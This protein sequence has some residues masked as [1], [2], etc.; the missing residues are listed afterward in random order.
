MVVMGDLCNFSRVPADNGD[1]GGHS[2]F[3]HFLAVVVVVV[4]VVEMRV[5]DFS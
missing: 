5:K 1:G 2:T 4:V 3:S